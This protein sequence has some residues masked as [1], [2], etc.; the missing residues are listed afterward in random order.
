[1]NYNSGLEALPSGRWDVVI[2][3]AGPA[4]ALLGYLLARLNWRVLIA[5]RSAFP[6]DKVCGGCLNGRALAALALAGLGGL[7]RKHGAAPLERFRLSTGRAEAELPLPTGEAI[8]RRSLDAALAQS[9]VDAGAAFVTETHVKAGPAGDGARPIALRRAQNEMTVHARCFVDASGLSGN[10]WREDGPVRRVDA[11]SR[12][13]AGVILDRE[14]PEYARGCIHMAW[15][16]QGY[17][18]LA[19]VEGGKLNIA[20]ALDP[21]WVQ[22]QGGLAAAASAVLGHAGWPAP[23]GLEEAPWK[24]S[25]SLTV[26]REPVVRER[27]FVF[28]DAAGYVEPFTGE[29]MAW[30]MCGAH[31]IAP[32]INEV[33]TEGYQPRH[34][35]AW[36]QAHA[37][38][39]RRRQRVCAWVARTLRHP[40][41]VH[42][43]LHALRMTP[44]LA[45]PLLKHI[46]GGAFAPAGRIVP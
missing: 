23:K 12:I 32:I 5:D 39:A 28:G 7:A 43:C 31:A 8:T 15:A 41:A 30:A 21:A 37:R 44:V 4:G 34:A 45:M 9:A 2:A 29:G 1:M 38:L 20:A 46:N 18:G 33:L 11:R 16:P 25:P 14:C 40:A 26:R 19:R 6:R 42:L 35:Q 24:G 17:V 36:T 27:A 13:G 22:A 10:V 3:G